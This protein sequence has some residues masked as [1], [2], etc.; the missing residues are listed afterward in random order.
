M[1]FKFLSFSGHFTYFM[2]RIALID[3]L[4]LIFDFRHLKSLYIH[5]LH[6]LYN[7]HLRFLF[8]FVYVIYIPV[9]IFRLH[10]FGLHYFCLLFLFTLFLF[11]SFIYIIHI[12]Y[13]C[14]ISRESKYWLNDFI[15]WK[16]SVV[17]E[18]MISD[19]K[20]TVNVFSIPSHI[21]EVD[22]VWNSFLDSNIFSLFT[23]NIVSNKKFRIGF[24]PENNCET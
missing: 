21:T 15:F 16:V 7:P 24:N 19:H 13:H 10:Y 5:Y 22:F 20:S 23:S 6:F 8:T 17:T 4:R 2:A 9:Y 12:I 14:E 1:R 18:R 11:T 3:N